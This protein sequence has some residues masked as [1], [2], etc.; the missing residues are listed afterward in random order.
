MK[1][2]K[3]ILKFIMF[4]FALICALVVACAINPELS[5]KLGNKVTSALNLS[6]KISE[7]GLGNV[8]SG[9]VNDA[10]NNSDEGSASGIPEIVN[11]GNGYVAPEAGK[12]SAPDDLAGRSG[13][14]S[15]EESREEISDE[16]A[17]NLEN[18][19]SKGSTGE[20]Y[21]FDVTMY[22]FYE[23]LSED[24]QT[25]Y[26]QIYAN[27]LE[28]NSSFYPAVTMNVS[29]VKTV[30]EAV[31]N[32]HPEL[33]YL[34]TT[35]SAKYISSGECVEIILKYNSLAN[36]LDRAKEV[37]EEAAQS[38]LSVANTFS[39][40]ASKEKYVHDALVQRADYSAAA[41]YN[42][43]AYSAL[44]NGSGVCAGYARAF[45]YLMMEMDVPCYYCTGYSGENHAWN[46]IC[47]DG[48][49]YNVDVT[50]DD[51][52]PATYDFYNKSDADY[53]A[54]HVRT[55]LSVNLPPCNNSLYVGKKSTGSDSEAAGSADGN[56]ADGTSTGGSESD[57]GDIT[58]DDYE[59][60]LNELE[61]ATRTALDELEGI[62]NPN[63]SQ[64][65]TL[66][67]DRKPGEE[68]VAVN[69]NGETVDESKLD[70]SVLKQYK[71][72]EAEVVKTMED[73]YKDCYEKLVAAGS[74]EVTFYT[75]I[76]ESMWS[77]VEKA[78]STRSFE[79]GFV[80]DALKKLG[81]NHLSIGLQLERL[82]GGY[83]RIYHNV[84]TY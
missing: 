3:G 15:I 34:D 60:A 30:F 5:V 62:I 18:S 26:R 64:P 12:V 31:Y 9:A 6:N 55:G 20:E 29:Q 44:V 53:A 7:E 81:M 8:V 51:T 69:G 33:F 83:T 14:A 61:D 75:V 78:Y 73:Y 54:T 13:L 52:D 2:V 74:G 4:I 77:S 50:W 58:D 68:K 84:Y 32:D 35:Y 71:I 63:P 11:G 25:L 46:I 17:K 79:A 37:F 59:K 70:P 39:D 47:V 19:L 10:L 76:P 45:Q 16:A 41:T 66:E 1:F 49:F 24:G 42:Q 67:N 82:G 36:D 22:P 80:N 38:I 23:M 43:S 56:S 28:L 27:A 57:P 72:T 48:I 65:I 21:S 40:T